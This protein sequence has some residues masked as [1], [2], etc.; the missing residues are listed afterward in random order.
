MTEEPSL[1]VRSPDGTDI[2]V[3]AFGSGSPLVLVHG[4]MGDHHND[5]GFIAELA[6]FS[7]VFAID[8]CGRGASSDHPEYS[9]EREFEDVAS[10]VDAVAGLAGQAVALWGHSFG[11]DVAL[12]A[13]SLT[14]NLDTLVLYEPG[15]GMPQPSGSVEAVEEALAAGDLEAAAVALMEKV[16][17]MTDEEVAY[18]RSLPTWPS[19]VELVPTVPRELVAESDWVY[20]AAWLDGVT[21]RVLILAGSESP[22]AQTD[23]T[24]RAAAAIPNARV[25]VLEGH[26]HI[27]HRT[28]PTM[29][30]DI[31]RRF[32]IGE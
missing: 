4:A 22:E 32:V 26:G 10:V 17:E 6:K 3:F 15:L 31:V 27:A 24:H 2:G 7:A 13:S 9:I 11:A 16:V 8:R 5:S 30:A 19:R 29:V 25:L 18:L 28:H 23:A 1:L 20:P 21:A 12:G 14:S